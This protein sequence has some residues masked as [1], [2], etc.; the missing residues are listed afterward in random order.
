MNQNQLTMTAGDDRTFAI[1]VD[2]D[3]EGDTFSFVVDGLFTKTGTVSA[4]DGSGSSMCTVTVDAD[5]TTGSNRPWDYGSDARYVRSYRLSI[6]HDG[7]RVTVRKGLLV[8][9]AEADDVDA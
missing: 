5:D 6:D 7:D 4:D 3:Y 1:T 9:T 2:D 8:V